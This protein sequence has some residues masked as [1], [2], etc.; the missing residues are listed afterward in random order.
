MN[1]EKA[2]LNVAMRRRR[3][4]E[5]RKR[6][7]EER[8]RERL[9]NVAATKVTTA[10]IGAL[11]RF[12]EGFG[13]CWG[14]GLPEGELTPRQARWREVWRQVRKGVLDNG[15]DQAHALMKEIETHTVFWNR[16]GID[17]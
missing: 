13:E 2:A 1:P 10:F 12:E 16:Y 7:Y 15:N 14:H 4:A 3:E 5:A 8:C 11:A 6:D 9:Q 17:L